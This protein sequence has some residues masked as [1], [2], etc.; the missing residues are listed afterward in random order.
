MMDK[1]G[2]VF[3][4]N[5]IKRMIIRHDGFKV[6]PS[7]I[8]D[9][10]CTIPGVELACAVAI[11]DNSKKQGD[12]PFVF[13][14]PSSDFLGDINE[15][16]KSIRNICSIELPEYVQPVGYNFIDKFPYTSIGKVDYLSLQERAKSIS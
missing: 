9:V 1:D 13:V 3:I 14:K 8:E 5:R 16:E 7:A 2:Y 15:L 10:I 12:L 11:S 6:F 4:I